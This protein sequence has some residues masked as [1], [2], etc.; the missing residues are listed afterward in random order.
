M[1]DVYKQIGAVSRSKTSV[2]VVG[3]SGTGKELVAKAIHF[4]SDPDKPFVAVNCT[5]FA[6]GLLESELF[7]HVRGA[8]TGAVADRAGR[9]ELAG[10]GSLLLDEIAEIPLDLQAK[11]LRVLQERTFERVG[12]AKPVPLRARIMAATHRN[13]SAMV[14]EGTFRE[15]LYY[16]LNV[17]E[18][19]L[20]ALRDRPEDIPLLVEGLLA[21]INR[22]LHRNVRRVT[23][24]A[25]RALT[26][27]AWPGNVRELEN[28]L[29]RAVVLAKGD[30]IDSDVLAQ[31]I[32]GVS[33]HSPMT[34]PASEEPLPL[35]DVERN[36]IERVLRHTD[37]NKKR[38]C[39][40]LVISR[41]TL[42][43]KIE[44]YGLKKEH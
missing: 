35:R 42:D 31:G 22:E 7:G 32:P 38:A 21:R 30:S 20:P 17:V 34:S 43:R 10:E 4:A 19:R 39:E 24:D 8:Y 44:E 36:H 2:L 27:Y 3:E 6:T 16:R 15:D 5:A 26:T 18:I 23:D 33:T 12:D 41:P 40:L 25:M 9:F 28:T 37:W 14:R 1:R 11:L 13:L 29:T